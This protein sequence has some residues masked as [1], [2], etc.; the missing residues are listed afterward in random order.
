[1]SEITRETIA[2]TAEALAWFEQAKRES[3]G[4][5]FWRTRDGRPEWLHDAIYAAHD[6]GELLPDDTVYEYVVDV[7]DALAEADPESHDEISDAAHEWADASMDTSYH[8]LTAWLHSHPSRVYLCD[9]AAEEF[10]SEKDAELWKQIQLGQ[11]LERLRIFEA[12]AEA[13]CEA[14]EADDDAA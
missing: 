1:M 8:D 14:A 10:W 9:E 11:Y 7:L 2:K 13:C 5:T 3:T 12:I 4:E 6:D